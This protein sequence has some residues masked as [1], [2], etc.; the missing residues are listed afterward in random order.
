V[1][2]RLFS[3]QSKSM[4]GVDIGTSRVKIVE[5][6]G[7]GDD[8]E[9]TRAAIELTPPGAIRDGQI[10]APDMVAEVIRRGLAKG[11]I[12]PGEV[13]AAIAG[14]GV[15]VR[16]VKFPRMPAEELREAIKWEGQ[17]YIPIPIDEAVVD[18]DIIDGF[19]DSDEAEMEV[20]L[21]AAP[22]K[23]VDSHVQAIELAGLT[24]IAIDVQPFTV[25]RALRYE[26]ADGAS[27]D[28]RSATSY[29]DIGAGTTDILIAQGGRLRFTR[30]VPLGGNTFTTAIA[31]KLGISFEEAEAIKIGKGKVCVD[32][33]D[34]PC[35]DEAEQSIS[36]AIAGVAADVARDIRRSLDYHDLQLEGRSRDAGVTKVVLTGGASVMEGLD[37][38]FESEL[39]LA[40]VMGDPLK[41]IAVNHRLANK[42]EL[43]K[44]GPMLA[45]GIGLAL[46]EVVD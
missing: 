35:T 30:I 28:G 46:R 10:V 42:E 9:L 19:S 32:G 27:Q 31:D 25:L 1:P 24:P 13:I 43:S 29:I 3:G 21:V 2:L 20:M 8:V 26:P 4:V 6:T 17:Q 11:R 45:V 37:Q 5:L 14:Q 36:D 22:R 33:H 18:F 44:L 16:H 41:S 39:G 12:K 7:R 23:L 40:T 34:E 15:V 38:Y